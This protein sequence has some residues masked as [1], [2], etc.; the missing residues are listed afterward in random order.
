MKFWG[1]LKVSPCFLSFLVTLAMLTFF[2]LLYFQLTYVDRKSVP[3][4]PLRIVTL[5]MYIDYRLICN[6]ELC[7]SL[8]TSGSWQSIPSKYY[9]LLHYFV[10]ITIQSE[11]VE[12]EEPWNIF[13]VFNL[14]D[15]IYRYKSIALRLFFP[16][17]KQS[18]LLKQ[19][20]N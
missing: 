9:R 3:Y 5:V 8:T 15:N 20:G 11:K 4:L 12:M 13:T 2:C 14:V 16:N 17:T 6:F 18:N 19:E 10:N 7:P 1:S